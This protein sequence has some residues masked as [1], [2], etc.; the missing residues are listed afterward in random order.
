MKVPGLTILRRI[1]E[2]VFVLL[3]AILAYLVVSMR[4]EIVSLRTELREARAAASSP[5][6]RVGEPLTPLPVH[7]I[8]GR[9]IVLDPR[10]ANRELLVVVVDPNCSDCRDAVDSA[11]K[12]LKGR[13]LIVLSVEEKGTR[14]F[15]AQEGVADFTY[16]VSLHELPVGMQMKLSHPPTILSLNPRATITRV[17]ARPADCA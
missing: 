3:F 12:Y 4:R 13:G 6:F 16:V 15:A 2:G 17:C 14:E 9:A 7:T 8:D 10:A 1:L 11:R 5:I